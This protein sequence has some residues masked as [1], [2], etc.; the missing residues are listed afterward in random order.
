MVLF[1]DLFSSSQNDI[2]GPLSRQRR[3]GAFTLLIVVGVAPS[4]L[5]FFFFFLCPCHCTV[6]LRFKSIVSD[7][8]LLFPNNDSAAFFTSATR[9]NFAPHLFPCFHFIMRRPLYNFFKET[10]S[11][12]VTIK[13]PQ[14][15]MN[16]LCGMTAK[17]KVQVWID[18]VTQ[19]FHFDAVCANPKSSTHSPREYI[20]SQAV[21]DH[22]NGKRKSIILCWLNS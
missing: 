20:D 18:C 19:R 22:A 3:R 14:Q 7:K 10:N 15:R 8:L 1:S 16:A 21:S 11:T 2:L 4:P 6:F 13:G 12:S 9:V 5:L 17:S